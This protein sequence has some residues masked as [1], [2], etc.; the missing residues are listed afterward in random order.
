MKT[1][2]R[3]AVLWVFLAKIIFTCSLISFNNLF[4]TKL[5]TL[6]MNFSY[7]L[8]LKL[9]DDHKFNFCLRLLPACELYSLTIL[10]R[11]LFFNFRICFVREKFKIISCPRRKTCAL[12]TL[13]I[14]LWNKAVIMFFFMLLLITFHFK[15][16]ALIEVILNLNLI[17]PMSLKCNFPLVKKV[18]YSFMI[19]YSIFFH[20]MK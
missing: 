4:W 16:L 20:L 11:K 9:I 8:V 10:S 14:F 13:L 17:L 18:L 3:I 12:M 7:L 2:L 15:N 19:P 6:F 5:V 1:L